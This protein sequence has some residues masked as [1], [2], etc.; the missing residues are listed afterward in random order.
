MHVFLTGEIQIGKSTVI[1]KTTALV[2]KNIGGFQTYFGPDRGLPNRRLYMN[3]A[4]ESKIIREENTIVQFREEKSPLVQ[5]GKFDT[6]G[7]KL[8]QNARKES[9]L[10]IM[11]ECGNLERKA[12]LFQ[13]EIL[14][15]LDGEIPIIGVMEI[16]RGHFSSFISFL[17]FANK[18][19]KITTYVG[20]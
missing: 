14:D 6:Y 19:Y 17:L 8:I 3:P 1:N 2:N 11:D 20:N 18:I 9:S 16:H 7:V 12:I 13:G 15:T 5:S 10:I 4:A